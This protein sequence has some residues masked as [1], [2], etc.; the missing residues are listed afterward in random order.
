V[1]VGRDE[2]EAAVDAVVDDGLAVEA[3]L[4]L[5][6]FLELDVDVVGQHLARLLAVHRIAETCVPFV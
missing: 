5:E 6:V 1:A 4:V 2:V 3:A